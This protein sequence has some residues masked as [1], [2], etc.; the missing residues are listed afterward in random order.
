MMLSHIFVVPTPRTAL[1]IVGA[2]YLVVL[3]VLAIIGV[4]VP[5]GINILFVYEAVVLT[6]LFYAALIFGIGMM[7][8]ATLVNLSSSILVRV[9][10]FAGCVTSSLPLGA[11]VGVIILWLAW[12]V[13][14]LY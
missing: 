6:Y 4:A 9:V 12:D 14:R 11:A 3:C 5:H 2:G 10:A 13:S 1:A 8:S 7:I